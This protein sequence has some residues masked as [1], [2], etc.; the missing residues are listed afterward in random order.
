MHTVVAGKTSA[1]LANSPP[2][3]KQTK[4][5]FLQDPNQRS[6]DIL[7]N[8]RREA[9]RHFRNKK[10]KYLKAKVDELET[11]NEINS[12][13]G[14]QPRTNIIKVEMGDLVTYSHSI[15]ARRRNHFSQLRNVHGANDVRQTEIHN[16][17]HQCLR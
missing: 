4:V 9:S 11:N 6:V 2:V 17:S 5:Q 14:Y 12:M 8:V 1:L 3:S 13:I 10:K 15:L 7:N 16:S